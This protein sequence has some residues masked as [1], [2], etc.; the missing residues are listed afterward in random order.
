MHT[1]DTEARHNNTKAL[2]IPPQFLNC[3]AW[4]RPGYTPE[5]QAL[6]P[7]GTQPASR[8][9]AR[10]HKAGLASTGSWESP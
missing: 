5:K 2:L 4:P 3:S 6:P 10:V 7:R 1:R 8:V 9:P